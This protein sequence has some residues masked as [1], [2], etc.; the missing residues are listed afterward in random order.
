MGAPSLK[1]T[2]DL[3]AFHHPLI[4]VNFGYAHIINSSLNKCIH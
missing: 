1:T 4:L 3:L 2:F